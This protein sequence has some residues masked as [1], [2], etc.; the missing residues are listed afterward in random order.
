MLISQIDRNDL[1]LLKF[2]KNEINSKLKWEHAKEFEYLGKMFDIVY[3]QIHSDSIFYYCWQDDAE[4]DLNHRFIAL[5]NS[6]LEKNSKTS[7]FFQLLISFSSINYLQQTIDFNFDNSS[8]KKNTFP[9]ISQIYENQ[10]LT[11]DFPP[12]KSYSLSLIVFKHF[13][14]LY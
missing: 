7:N 4:T 1:V 2:S 6:S 5:F 10:T 9:N 13:F 14:K 12:P 3:T 11:P 8:S